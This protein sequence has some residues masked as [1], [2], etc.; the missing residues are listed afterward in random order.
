[1]P[2]INDENVSGRALPGSQGG[3]AGEEERQPTPV[4][5]EEDVRPDHGQSQHLPRHAE[6]L[7][8]QGAQTA[9]HQESRLRGAH[10]QVRLF[11][12]RDHRQ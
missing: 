12:H 7:Q 9:V 6:A 4:L 5:E 2:N 3:R 10:R 1:M 11:H 8:G